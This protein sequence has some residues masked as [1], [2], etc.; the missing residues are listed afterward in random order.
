MFPVKTKIVLHPL[1]INRLSCILL[2]AC[3]LLTTSEDLFGKTIHCSPDSESINLDLFESFCFM[4]ETYTVGSTYA[5]T[6]LH[7]PQIQK[8]IGAALGRTKG[9]R[10]N[11]QVKKA[12]YLFIKYY[13]ELLAL[14]TEN[15]IVQ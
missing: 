2:L 5:A 3:S 10:N 13:I 15:G 14:W 9:Q 7:M 6:N 4:A 11:S 8:G 1:L 12:L